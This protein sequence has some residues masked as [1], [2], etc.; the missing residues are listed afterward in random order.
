MEKHIKKAVSE[1]LVHLG[2]DFTDVEIDDLGENQF[3]VNVVSDEPS[4]LIGHHGENLQAMQKILKVRFHKDLGE[5]MQVSF[6]VDNYR[7]RQEENVLTITQ[8][9]IEEVRLT[10]SQVSLPPM[11]PYFRR[12]VHMFIRDGEYEDLETESVGEGNYR[13]VVIKLKAA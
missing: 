3:R 12:V 7:K 1:F 9:K 13:Q 4:L 11:S 10:Q 6:D 8:Q 5:E 2:I